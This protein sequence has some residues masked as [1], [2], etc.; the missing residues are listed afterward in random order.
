MSI[1]KIQAVKLIRKVVGGKT[2]DEG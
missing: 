2:V 1:D